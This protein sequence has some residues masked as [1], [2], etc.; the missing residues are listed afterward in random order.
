MDRLMMPD[1]SGVKQAVNL[2]LDGATRHLETRIKTKFDSA[3]YTDDFFVRDSQTTSR[4][5]VHLR[6][7]AGFVAAAPT[8][9]A[10]TMALLTETSPD[11]LRSYNGSDLTVLGAEKG[12]LRVDGANL[13][14]KYVRVGYTA[15]FAVSSDDANL[16]DQ[17]AVPDWLKE[18]AIM[19]AT[20]L[21]YPNPVFRRAEDRSAD[22][23]R[24]IRETFE[25]SLEGHVRYTPRALNPL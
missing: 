14:D 3:A 2:A 21:L 25:I 7:T 5:G 20:I 23:I 12:V 6:L 16:Y 10:L 15:G 13:T 8:Y 18:L 4:D 22:E 9:T 11:N 17:A 19:Q 24:M 1:K